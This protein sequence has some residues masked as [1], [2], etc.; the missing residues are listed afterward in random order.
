MKQ[1]HIQSY[2]KWK[3]NGATNNSSDRWDNDTCQKY[4]KKRNILHLKS[5]HPMCWYSKYLKS[6][7]DI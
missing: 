7:D 3:F 2:C 1:K 5:W 6:I 4:C